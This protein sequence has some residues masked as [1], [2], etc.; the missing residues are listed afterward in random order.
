MSEELPD[1]RFRVNQ[2]GV[3]YIFPRDVFFDI[4]DFYLMTGGDLPINLSNIF[5]DD[6]EALGPPANESFPIET[7]DPDT[8]E[9]DV[10]NDLRDDWIKAVFSNEPCEFIVNLSSLVGGSFSD[11]SISN[12]SPGLEM[13]ILEDSGS[14]LSIKLKGIPLPFPG[15]YIDVLFSDGSEQR[16]VRYESTEKLREIIKKRD[17][18]L[19]VISRAKLI[20]SDYIDTL[21][22]RNLFQSMIR[23]INLGIDKRTSSRF[24][25]RIL[26]LEKSYD[27]LNPQIESLIFQY[28]EMIKIIDLYLNSRVADDSIQLEDIDDIRREVFDQDRVKRFVPIRLGSPRD[29]IQDIPVQPDP[30]FPLAEEQPFN[31]EVGG[32]DDPDPRFDDPDGIPLSIKRKNTYTFNFTHTFQ[33]KISASE[34]GGIEEF[35]TIVEEASFVINQNVIWYFETLIDVFELLID[36]STL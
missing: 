36:R 13:E 24:A 9:V 7:I 32:G 15:E 30:D 4:Q 21:P 17:I 31:T 25:V 1:K 16:T 18:E 27:E 2:I 12:D 19:S 8:G 22:D 20:L 35:R 33:I 34:E 6:Y 28:D 10:I 29:P 3:D 26:N 14:K 23:N 11:S 5:G